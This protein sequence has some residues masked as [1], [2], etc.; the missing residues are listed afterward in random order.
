MNKLLFCLK[1]V[2]LEQ[3]LVYTQEGLERTLDDVAI[4][5]EEL[6]SSNEELLVSNAAGRMLFEETNPDDLVGKSINNYLNNYD[7]A[8]GENVNKSTEQEGYIRIEDTVKCVDKSK[9][10]IV[11]IT[12]GPILIEEYF[13]IF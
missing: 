3:E 13:R 2:Y 6:Q 4:A 1:I 9:R 5:G 8:Y 11:E 7:V 10:V 12:T